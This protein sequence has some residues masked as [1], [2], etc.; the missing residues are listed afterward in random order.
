MWKSFKELSFIDNIYKSLL[1]KHCLIFYFL[2]IPF[3]LCAQ[4]NN[5]VEPFVLEAVIIDAEDLGPIPYATIISKESN[6]GTVSNEN[7]YFRLDG[8]QANASVK[9]SFIGYKTESYQANELPDTIYLKIKNEVLNEVELLADNSFLYYLL[10]RSKKTSSYVEHNAKSYFSLETHVD[11]NQ[12]EL[13]E[14]YYNGAYQSYD[15]SSLQMKA[16]RTALKMYNNE[17]FVSLET[18]KSLYMHQLFDKNNYFPSSPFE[19]S[20]RKLKKTY[21]LFLHRKYKDDNGNTIYVV[22]YEPKEAPSKYFKGRVWIDSLSSK[23]QKINLKIEQASIFPFVAL[24]EYDSLKNVNME[25]T[26]NFKEIDGVPYVKS[27]DF[28][29]K[30]SYKVRGRNT[31][32]LGDTSIVSDAK[33]PIQIGLKRKVTT[34]NITSKALLYAYDYEETFVLPFMDFEVLK[35]S[36]HKLINAIPFNEIFWTHMDEFRFNDEVHNN[37]KFLYEEAD[38]DVKT[39]YKKNPYFKNGFIEYTYKHWDT[40]RIFFRNDKQTKEDYTDYMEWIP[41]ERYRLGGQLVLD[42][43]EFDDSLYVN[44]YSIMDPYKTFYHFPKKNKDYAFMNM[45]FDLLEIHRRKFEKEINEAPRS[46]EGI[47]AMYNK[48]KEHLERNFQN[49]FKDVVRGTNQNGMEKWNKYIY[50]NIGIDN[51]KLFELDFEQ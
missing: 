9:I 27:I 20:K 22:D 5:K 18:S 47:I 40:K 4:E 10:S 37:K 13:V 23:I 28:D 15:L 1:M 2:L 14:A 31:K 11:T 24:T 48:K 46:I 29:Y 25:I 34:K 49:F 8:L 42:L 6:K 44:T 16:G 41:S 45:Y 35:M 26:K 50:E 38:I 7:G 51:M 19:F 3:F 33:R 43:N 30:L 21:H 12:V 36:D 32:S 17:A 39:L